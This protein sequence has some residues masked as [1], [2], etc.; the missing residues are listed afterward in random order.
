MQLPSYGIAVGQLLCL[1]IAW[2][3]HDMTLVIN[4]YAAMSRTVCCQCDGVRLMSA[5]GCGGLM[6]NECGAE[7]PMMPGGRCSLVYGP[8]F[9][10]RD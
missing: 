5:G 1:H 7:C 6:A 4:G 2:V 9:P 8:F 3:G 10:V